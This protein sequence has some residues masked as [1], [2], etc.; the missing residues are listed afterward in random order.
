MQ[1]SLA[2]RILLEK[3]LKKF[4]YIDKLEIKYSEYDKPF[5]ANSDLK[6][7][8][9]HSGEIVVCVLS[10]VSD[11]GIDIE[12]ISP[13]N[14]EDFKFQMTYTE[15]EKIINAE[16]RMHS[17]YKYWTQKEAVIKAHGNGLSIPLPSFEVN[18]NYTKID[19]DEFYLKEIFI[20]DFYLC[21]I[22]LIENYDVSGIQVERIDLP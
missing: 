12:L 8:I 7:N 10:N 3:G 20:D 21:Y 1:A 18:N 2:G 6:F 22:A 17:F 11:T 4:G 16:D 14:I 15:W 9:S 19:N 13:I 5:F